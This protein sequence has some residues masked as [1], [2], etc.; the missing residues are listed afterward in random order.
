MPRVEDTGPN[1]WA[2]LA[3]GLA[4]LPQHKEPLPSTPMLIYIGDLNKPNKAFMTKEFFQ[5]YSL[6]KFWYLANT[7]KYVFLN[8]TQM[9]QLTDL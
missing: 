8:T 7:L 4:Q 9:L 3:L 2:A 5:L 6:D 1:R